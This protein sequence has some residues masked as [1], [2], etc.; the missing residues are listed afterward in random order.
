[1]TKANYS[2]TKENK[3][4]DSTSQAEMRHNA[5]ALMVRNK[6]F[7]TPRQVR[8]GNVQFES[9]HRDQNNRP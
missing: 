1:M 9:L 8:R 6:T 5:A 7:P 4:T 2:Y 3:D